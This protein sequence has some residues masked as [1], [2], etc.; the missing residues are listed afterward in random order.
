MQ[1]R[2][3][4]ALK[5]LVLSSKFTRNSVKLPDAQENSC[6]R[7]CQTLYGLFNRQVVISGKYLTRGG[8][9]RITIRPGPVM[10][11]KYT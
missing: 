11:G 9:G 7:V 2:P 10:S 1:G 4:L 6:R 8:G 3:R 5:Y